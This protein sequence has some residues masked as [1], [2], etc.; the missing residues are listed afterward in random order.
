MIGF[1][2]F[3]LEEVAHSHDGI[4]DVT[5]LPFS[6]GNDGV[7]HAATVL[8][9]IHNHFLGRKVDS[10]LLVPMSGLPAIVFGEKRGKFHAQT[11]SGT[12]KEDKESLEH[13]HKIMPREGGTYG[14]VVF[15]DKST[16]KRSKGML[17]TTPD[18]VTYSVNPE[19]AEGRKMKNA[20]I[21]VI[22][23]K[24][25]MGGHA[26]NLTKEDR[27]KFQDHPDVYNVDPHLASNPQNYTPE[28][29]GKFMT[30]FKNAEMS[31]S[32]MKPETLEAIA[33]HADH[34]IHHTDLVRTHGGKPDS[35]TYI[36]GLAAHQ[37]AAVNRTASMSKKHQLNQQFADQIQHAYNNKDHIEKAIQISNHLHGA[38]SALL[39]V[40]AK[41]N[42][43]MHSING[44]A[45]E[46]AGITHMDQHGNK[47]KLSR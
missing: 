32:K 41:N 2:N 15:H 11:V 25:F 37:K 29:Q 39:D 24:K 6:H 18:N 35:D 3:L 21:G 26:Q 5:H 30:H 47:V 40:A 43:F 42:P 16:L 27:A 9:D 46:P 31:Y 36:A 38:K 19:S 14:G 12:L 23:D 45:V 8:T 44:A 10:E 28:E 13:L 4:A 1:K 17:S 20:K 7:G 34:L 22:L 33:P